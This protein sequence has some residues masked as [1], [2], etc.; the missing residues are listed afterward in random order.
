VAESAPHHRQQ[1][2]PQPQP[3]PQWQAPPLAQWHVAPAPAE[4]GE[5][6]LVHA[7]PAILE[8]ASEGRSLSR[9]SEADAVGT[10]FGGGHGVGGAAGGGGSWGAGAARAAMSRDLTASPEEEDEDEDEE[11]EVAL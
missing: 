7:M 6:A 4:P 2:H 3:Q 5:Y 8:S 11:G 9:G 1:P 10:L